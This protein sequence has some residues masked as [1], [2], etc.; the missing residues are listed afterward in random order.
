MANKNLRIN[1]LKALS[2]SLLLPSLTLWGNDSTLSNTPQA[3]PKQ[4]A[5]KV[6]A[7]DLNQVQ[8]LDSPFKVAQTNVRDYLMKLNV[9]QLLY[10]FLREVGLP[11]PV[12]GSDSYGYK[13][14]GHYLGHYLSGCALM[15]RNTGNE[16]LKKRADAAVA[17]LAQCQQKIGTGFVMGFS[18]KAMLSFIETGVLGSA[19]DP[20]SIVVPWYCIHK[21]YAGLLDMYQLTGNR[22][23]LNVLESSVGWLEK[24]M[25]SITGK[26]LDLLVSSELGGMNEVLANLYAVT[27][28][29]E[30]LQLAQK[31]K[32]RDLF[33]A[34]EKNEDP[35]D[36]RH[37]NSRIP[38]FVGEARQAILTGD[39]ALVKTADNFW[40]AVAKERSYV[41]GG[42]SAAEHF[43][44]KNWLSNA[45]MMTSE[46]CNSYNMLKLTRWL[47]L[48]DARADLADYFERTLY[49]H[50]LSAQNPQT[51][52]MLYFHQ[53][54]T[55]EPKTYKWSDPEDQRECCFGSGLESHSK[56]AESIYFYDGG[57]ALYVNLFIPSELDWKA[58][59]LTVRQE[60]AY[61]DEEATRLL[62]A[63]QKPIA[64]SVKIR[65]PWW[66]TADFQVKINGELQ[67]ISSTPGSYVTL[68][69]TWKNG[70][71]VEV[72][73]PMGLR[74]EAFR[75]NPR[76]L[77]L[78]Y[79][80]MVLAAKTELNNRFSAIRANGEE[81][82][83]SLKPISGK[84]LEFTA[85]AENFRTS[86]LKVANEPVTFKPLMRVVDDPKIV[87]W[88]RFTE[89]EFSAFGGL[90]RAEAERHRQLEPATVDLVLCAVDQKKFTEIGK[91]SFQGLLLGPDGPKSIF[92]RSL[93]AVAEDSHAAKIE[94]ADQIA[95]K[96]NLFPKGIFHVFRF[97]PG[98]SI[99]GY[100]MRVL[101]DKEQQVQVRLWRPQYNRIG[102]QAKRS[103]SFEVLVD[104]TPVGSCKVEDLP[105]DQFVDK[106]FSIPV[107]LTQGKSQVQVNFR[108][109][110][111]GEDALVGFYE[112]RI[113][114]K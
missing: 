11:T 66:A 61:P 78:M 101:P 63:S 100:G 89:Q 23:A 1:A 54:G 49:N 2:F 76:R 83:K 12:N 112:C 105:Y 44:R 26:R 87:Y 47:F 50:I 94:K 46:T 85:P 95:W 19:K 38:M 7:F 36:F 28:R 72:L 14:T 107:A 57:D 41:T 113:V 43:P 70:D 97:I 60:T 74:V 32:H 67:K 93:E 96:T 6:L 13:Y 10:P 86:P 80:P 27:G 88:D 99:V 92:P 25:A 9:D 52:G 104:G 102:F 37:A 4:G 30:H 29:A 3:I 109:L 114:K 15:Y 77:A 40:T 73:M 48:M 91:F 71:K 68:E 64:A 51:G 20:K 58:K 65:R 56:Y 31:F 84:P 34:F 108:N 90:F 103:G 16:E 45:M 53:L 21:V 35:L 55:G 82:L 75:D 98:S 8:L 62:F 111:K 24:Q 18:E 17:V 81:F 42:N 79:G 110:Q 106:S 39:P 22:Q 5:A 33:E 69:R 59:G